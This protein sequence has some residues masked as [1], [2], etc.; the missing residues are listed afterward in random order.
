MSEEFDAAEKRLEEGHPV[1]RH[2]SCGVLGHYYDPCDI[3]LLLDKVRELG[4]EIERLKSENVTLLADVDDLTTVK[5]LRSELAVERER[6]ERLEKAL[7]SIESEMRGKSYMRETAREALRPATPEPPSSEKRRCDCPVPDCQ[8]HR[9]LAS[10]PDSEQPDLPLGHKFV[11]CPSLMP[12]GFPARFC[13]LTSPTQTE[14]HF[15]QL[16]PARYCGLPESAHRR[17]P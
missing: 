15:W 4:E 7:E 6:S 17:K 5:R 13:V 3:R 9:G 2:A 16:H 11:P 12:D 14:C 1:G 10:Y 8:H